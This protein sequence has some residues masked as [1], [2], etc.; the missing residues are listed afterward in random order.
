MSIATD[1]VTFFRTRWADRL[2]DTCTGRRIDDPRGSINTSTY[3]YDSQSS[4]VIYTTGPCLLRPMGGQ[5]NADEFGQES[6][7]RIGY[8]LILP[9]DASGIIPD[10]EFTIDTSVTDSE[11]VGKILIV[12]GVIYDSYRVK[13]KLVCELDLGGGLQV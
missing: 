5:A 7:T 2:V 13:T 3:Q 6:Q 9:F 1:H 10:D 11:M 12:R 4:T 8:T